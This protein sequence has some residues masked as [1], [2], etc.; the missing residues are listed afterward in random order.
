VEVEGW[1]EVRTPTR[2]IR[3][4][5]ARHRLEEGATSGIE[6]GAMGGGRGVGASEGE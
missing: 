5:V 1:A 2:E 3:R 6:E 4:E